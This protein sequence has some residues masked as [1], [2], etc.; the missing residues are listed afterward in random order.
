MRPGCTHHRDPCC[1]RMVENWHKWMMRQLSSDGEGRGLP[2][3]LFIDYDDSVAPC[4]LGALFS[5]LE[6]DGT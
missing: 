4:E 3:I 5:W 6:P 1:R 2:P